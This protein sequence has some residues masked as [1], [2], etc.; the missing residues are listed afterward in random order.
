MHLDIFRRGR[1]KSTRP[2]RANVRVDKS[3]IDFASTN[4][5]AKYCF[6]LVT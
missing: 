2:T 5:G 6:L 4:S 1:T 3:P